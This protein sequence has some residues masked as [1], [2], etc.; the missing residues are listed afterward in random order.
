MLIDTHRSESELSWQ[1]EKSNLELYNV[2]VELVMRFSFLMAVSKGQT[3]QKREPLDFYEEFST[4]IKSKQ[5][6]IR[7]RL[8]G[9]SPSFSHSGTLLSRTE[10]RHSEA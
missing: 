2:S 9:N 10:S 6:Q 3:H 4:R 8:Q 7:N 1:I 5:F